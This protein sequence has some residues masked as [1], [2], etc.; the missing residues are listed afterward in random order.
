MRHIRPDR[1][2]WTG[3]GGADAQAQ[4]P[5]AQSPERSVIPILLGHDTVEYPKGILGRD[6][7]EQSKAYN[8]GER[9]QGG[10]LRVEHFAFTMMDLHIVFDNHLPFGRCILQNRIFSI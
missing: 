6:L 4:R 5:C 2:Q 7:R 8:D 3:E 9:M 1:V 10:G